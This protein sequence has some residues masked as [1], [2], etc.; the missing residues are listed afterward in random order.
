M[1]NLCVKHF[2]KRKARNFSSPKARLFSGCLGLLDT[3]PEM[4]GILV[5]YR[6]IKVRELRRFLEFQT[7]GS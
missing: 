1:L 5:S 6:Q 3:S 4:A 2:V 7:K